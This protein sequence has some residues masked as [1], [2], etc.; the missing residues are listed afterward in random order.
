MTYQEIIQKIE[1]L[2][3][4]RLNLEED[5]F[6]DFKRITKEIKDLQKQAR[7]SLTP[8]DR[9]CLAR[10]VNRPRAMEYINSLF[11]EFIELHGDYLFSDD[12]AIV[13]GIGMLGKFPV[14][15]LAQAKG[16]TIQDNIKRNFGSS[17]PEGFRKAKRLA[18]QAEKF[19]R[20]IITIIDT[21]GAYPGRGAEERGQARAIAEDIMAFSTL[22]VPVI[23]I[24]IG[25]GGSGGALA[26]S[27]ANKIYMLENSVY[28]I[29]SPEGFSSILFKD[30]SKVVE[31]ANKMKL[32]SFDLLN[33][34]VADEIIDEGIEGIRDNFKKIIALLKDKIIADLE[35]FEKKDT[36]Y[37]VNQRYEKFRKIGAIQ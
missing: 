15:V 22:K 29:L 35:A 6:N 10:D 19:N 3:A 12:H 1:M 18:L 36:A 9:V 37:V 32:T 8:W 17:N 5:S 20:P 13:G 28:S 26:L 31:S 4:E 30:A 21:S 2:R 33:Y 14:T 27:V 23:S 7:E 16:K 24:I 11:D 34:G 25:E